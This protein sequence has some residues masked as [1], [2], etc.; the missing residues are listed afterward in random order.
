MEHGLISATSCCPKQ[1]N[2][3]LSFI[4]G[5]YQ[6][7][8]FMRV[9][10][11]IPDRN[12]R[13]ELL[14]NCLRTMDL[15]TIKPDVFLINYPATS[16]DYDITQRYRVGYDQLRGKGYDIIFFIENDDAYRYN[17]IEKMLDH[18]IAAGKPDLFGTCTT[19]YYHLALRAWFKMEHHQRA[20]MMNTMMIP[21][22][23]IKWC[24]DNEP[25]TDLF[26]WF[27]IPSRQIFMPKEIMSFGV[28]HGVGK[29]V[30]G[31]TFHR[32]DQRLIGRFDQ[33][34]PD[35]TWLRE[36]TDPETFE[37]YKNYADKL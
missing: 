14:A 20:S 31:D 15:Q 29:I 26:L 17:F 12:D 4:T 32:L 6:L 27:N 28:K 18:W 10:A 33:K 24:V 16:E 34:D 22:L 9:A 23:E 37:F 30:H 2:Y 7:I 1:N 21:D 35:F 11:V 3:D 5:K 25:F 36:N 19:I 8:L 13:P